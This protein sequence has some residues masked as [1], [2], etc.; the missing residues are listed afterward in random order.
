MPYGPYIS[1]FQL[2]IYRYEDECQYDTLLVQEKQEDSRFYPQKVHKK[3]KI[4][5]NVESATKEH[6]QLTNRS[7]NHSIGH[8]RI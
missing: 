3:T 5:L 7:I 8:T 2:G 1:V 4:M 6:S